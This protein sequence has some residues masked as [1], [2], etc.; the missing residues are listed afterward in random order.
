MASPAKPSALTGAV[1]RNPF[2]CHVYDLLSP[3]GGV[4]IRA[5]FGGFGISYQ[6]RMFGL[7]DDGVL[8]FK[9]GD[10]N[11]ADY[12]ARDLPRFLYPTKNG[13]MELSYHRAPAEAL[14]D[15]DEACA[16]AQKS[17]ALS[18]N[19]PASKPAPKKKSKPKKSQRRKST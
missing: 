4:T 1:A 18:V 8:Y 5:M 6:G 13:P 12:V 7:I 14:D 10:S 9:V 19:K 11:R 16:W 2:A 3:L 17:I 15:S